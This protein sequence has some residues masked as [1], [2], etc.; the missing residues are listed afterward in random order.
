MEATGIIQSLK[1]LAGPGLERFGKAFDA[2]KQDADTF[3][4]GWSGAS[5]HKFY[6]Y[7]G[8]TPDHRMDTATAPHVNEF[9]NS[10]NT[11]SQSVLEIYQNVKEM[12]V[13][14]RQ[15][16]VAMEELRTASTGITDEAKGIQDGIQE[17]GGAIETIERVS[18]EVVSNIGEITMGLQDI[19][20]TV[21]GVN[22]QALGEIA[23]SLES[24]AR[25]FQID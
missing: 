19:S 13:G 8:T 9:L 22:D 4:F 3:L 7:I 11:V 2:I 10:I 18:Q 6:G 20:R 15:I 12:D 21:H 23:G 5:I 17:V 25:R 1:E 14:S 24:A 16:L